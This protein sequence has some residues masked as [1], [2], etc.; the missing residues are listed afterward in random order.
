MERGNRSKNMGIMNK[1]QLQL[2]Q[3]GGPR[4]KT[5]REGNFRAIKQN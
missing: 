1:R 4:A 2:H 5:T 3:E